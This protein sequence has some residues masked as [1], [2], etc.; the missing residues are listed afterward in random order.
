[1]ERVLIAE[2]H[3]LF[4]SAL[5]GAV[6]RVAPDAEIVE[7]SSLAEA[8]TALEVEEA[9]MVLL[10]L[11][12]SDSDGFAGLLELRARHPAIPVVVVSASEDPATARHALVLGASG[13]IPKSA[14]LGLIGIALEAILE[15]ET[16]S[17]GDAAGDAIGRASP[18]NLTP[19]QVRILA[20]MQRGSLNKQIAHEMGVSEATIKGHI[21]MIFR[22]MG[23]TNRTQ[24]V[25]A[26][27]SLTLPPGAQA[28]HN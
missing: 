21:T 19:A 12:M 7:C 11:K 2:D 23:V 6:A 1:M 17:P 24:A 4:R 16:W 27:R 22:K 28:E 18:A 26:A 25:L 14:D 20:A 3:P 15:G 13:F 5:A 9:A 10:D 8:L